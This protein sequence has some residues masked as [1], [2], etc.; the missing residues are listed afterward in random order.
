MLAPERRVLRRVFP[1]AE[2]PVGPGCG[3]VW[4]RHWACRWTISEPPSPQPS[5]TPTGSNGQSR[6]RSPSPAGTAPAGTEPLALD[7]LLEETHQTWSHRPGVG[8]RNLVINVEPDL[9]ASPASTAGEGRVM[10]RRPHSASANRQA[11]ASPMPWPSVSGFAAD[12]DL[13]LGDIDAV[14]PVCYVD[15]QSLAGIPGGHGDGAGSVRGCVVQQHVQDLSD[16]AAP[17][18]PRTTS[19]LADAPSSTPPTSPSLRIPPRRLAV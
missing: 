10:R 2:D 13:G 7:G 3:Y 8:Q 17:C 16:G 12:E 9:P 1:P 15:R 18:V 4:K 19:G 5:A 6:N 11:T 14:S